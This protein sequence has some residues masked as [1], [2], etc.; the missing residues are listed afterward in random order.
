MPRFRTIVKLFATSLLLA[1]FAW[2]CSGSD[3]SGSGQPAAAQL[4]A[5][6][7]QL[8][9]PS[10]S[11]IRP[12][13]RFPVENTCF[14]ENQSPPLSWSKAPAGTQSFALI[15]DEPEHESGSW[16]HWVLFNIPAG[17]TE[18]SPGIPTTTDS[19][20]DDSRQG[21][22]DFKNIGYNGPCPEPTV[23]SY[24]TFISRAGVQTTVP[25]R[26]YQV[27]LYALDAVLDLAGGATR[28]ELTSAMEGHVLARAETAGK[29]TMAIG[30]EG[31][32]GGSFLQ[33]A[34]QGTQTPSEQ[35]G[36]DQEKIYN[37]FGELITPTPAS[38]Q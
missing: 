7:F 31:K 6:D 29:F 12:R 23:K 16:A 4:E 33:T 24:D 38:G 10:F 5:S 13:K 19:L 2:G 25:P 11:D 17:A 35:A 20:P 27:T 36:T 3:D 26:K 34:K 28:N 8:V 21:T 37:S 14:G 22:N 30:L 9:S 1:L 15:A 18:L 32:E